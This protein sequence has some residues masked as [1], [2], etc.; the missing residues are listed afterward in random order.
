MK[1]FGIQYSI[2][3]QDKPAN[4]ARVGD[5]LARADPPAGSLIVLPEMFAT[6]F[7]MN[8]AT[9]AEEPDGET[10]Q[11][12]AATARS[13]GVTLVGGAAI[14][15]HGKQVSRHQ[16]IRCGQGTAVLGRVGGG[17]TGR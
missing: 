17:E 10:G 1:V 14:R 11:F 9:I 12:L 16:R 3:W 7:S 4:F 6:G 5:L 15:P 2:T 13:F 8:A